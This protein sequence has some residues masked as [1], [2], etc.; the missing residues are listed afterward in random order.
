MRWL[1][2]EKTMYLTSNC[3]FK[4]I[5]FNKKHADYDE[6]CGVINFELAINLVK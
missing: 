4:K 2:A 1:R 5:K 3:H 6:E